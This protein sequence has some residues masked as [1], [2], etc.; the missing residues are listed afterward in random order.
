M[1]RSKA[2]ESHVD[3]R[4]AW[5]PTRALNGML[6]F[7]DELG[8]LEW[9]RTGRVNIWIKKPG[10]W[11]RLKQ[12]LAK[13]FVWTGLI[14]DVEVFEL[15]SSTARFK[16]AHLV[17]DLG[18]K[19]PYARIDFLKD[20]LGVVVKTGD[21]THSTCIEI[22]FCYPDWAERNETVCVQSKKMLEVAQK[23]LEVNG[24]MFEEN[25]KAIGQFTTVMQDLSVT[26][27]LPKQDRSMVV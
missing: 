19:L 8:R 21:I 9:F 18:E 4:I 10:S 17:Q 6:L 11:A 3:N 14:Q 1:D 5:K 26:K 15:W 20:S 7:K 2:C 22:E 24:R 25:S 27:T 16:G 13:G 12:L 23:S